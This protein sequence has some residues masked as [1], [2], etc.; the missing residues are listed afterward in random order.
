MDF[1]ARSFV[2]AV[3]PVREYPMSEVHDAFRLMQ[4]VGHVGKTVLGWTDDVTVLAK[5]QKLPGGAATLARS[6][7][8][9]YPNATYLGR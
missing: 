9:L 1:V 2:K 6:Y 7:L 3:S 8:R 5:A 4:T